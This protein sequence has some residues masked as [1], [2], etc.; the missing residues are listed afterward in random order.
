MI[1]ADFPARWELPR[2]AKFGK[3]YLSCTS[4]KVKKRKEALILYG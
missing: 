3:N 4:L 2:V 1:N